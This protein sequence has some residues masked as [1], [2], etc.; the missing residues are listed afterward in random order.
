MNAIVEEL[1]NHHYKNEEI[2]KWVKIYKKTKNNRIQNKQFSKILPAAIKE[3]KIIKCQKVVLLDLDVYSV[4][5]E[6]E[7]QYNSLKQKIDETEETLKKNSPKNMTKNNTTNN[8][9]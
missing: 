8:K 6:Y 1:I 4:L 5:R 7:S 2:N 3:R 9:Q